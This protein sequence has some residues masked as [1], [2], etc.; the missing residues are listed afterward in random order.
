[1]PIR[2][3]SSARDLWKVLSTGTRGKRRRGDAGKG[4]CKS[5]IENSK[6][7]L[8]PSGRR[9]GDTEIR[10]HGDTEETGK[11]VRSGWLAGDTI[12]RYYQ[13]LREDEMDN[14]RMNYPAV[15]V[16]GIVYWLVQA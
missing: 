1:M 12:G 11:S 9:R 15:V 5:K 7:K 3:D 14:G 10:G 2:W 4:D 16:A 6:C 8:V 13:N